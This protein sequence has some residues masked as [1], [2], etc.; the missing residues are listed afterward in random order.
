MLPSL[1]REVSLAGRI[2]PDI[3]LIAD[4][5]SSLIWRVDLE[6]ADGKPTSRVRN[7]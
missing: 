5:F 6:T 1:L 3:M 7:A 2:A 4:C